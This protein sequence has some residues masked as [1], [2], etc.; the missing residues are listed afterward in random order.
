MRKNSTA[1]FLLETSRGVRGAFLAVVLCSVFNIV[2]AFLTPQ[3][4]S[5]TVDS[6]IG[7]MEELIDEQNA[8]K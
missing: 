4:L 7:D 6:I 3:I 1:R 2:F 5:F 8:A